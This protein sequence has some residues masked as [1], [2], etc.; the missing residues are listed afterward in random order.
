MPSED[1]GPR[2]RDWLGLGHAPTMWGMRGSQSPAAKAWMERNWE[3]C[4]AARRDKMVLG[5]PK[6]PNQDCVGK[7]QG[8]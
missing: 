2:G 8:G 7:F 6:D 1:P 3:C 4:S 5:H